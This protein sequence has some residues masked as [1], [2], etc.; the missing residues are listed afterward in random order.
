MMI[1]YVRDTDGKPVGCMVAVMVGYAVLVG[2]SFYHAKKEKAVFRK[3]VAKQIAYDRVEKINDNHF[4]LPVERFYSNAIPE[5][6][7][8]QFL[9][10]CGR[11]ERYFR[12]D[13]V[14]TY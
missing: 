6:A 11:C 9:Y 5:H 4:N 1:Q 10:F 8:D 12:T 7:K 3:K 14:F 13:V 2:Y